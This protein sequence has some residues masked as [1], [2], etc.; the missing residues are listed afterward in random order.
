MGFLK[1][2][3]LVKQQPVYPPDP[4]KS[5]E[6]LSLGLGGFH[7]IAYTEWGDAG[8]KD[9]LVCVHGLTRN[10]RDF[11]PLA[12]ALSATRRVICPDVVGRGASGRLTD[13]A[14]YSYPQY[15]ADMAAVIARIGVAELDWLGTS[16]GGLIGMMMAGRPNT[17]IRR[18]IL[19]DVGPFIPRKALERIGTYVGKDP[20]FPDHAA[21]IAYFRDVMSTWGR[22]EDEDYDRVVEHGVV[23]AEGGFRLRYD[24]SIAAPF[25]GPLAEVDLWSF[26]DAIRCPVLV[27]RGAE[28][29]L[30][31]AD[32]AEKMKT[33]GPGATVVS[34]P[35][36]GHAPALM[37]AEQIGI[38]RDW[39]AST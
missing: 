9:V 3:G 20:L 36:I 22:L 19:N 8:A 38:I 27:I 32:T 14:Q 29:D 12:K 7:K 30:L 5:R 28:S 13:K 2:F 24:P 18:L 33:R 11:D 10:G 17:P 31:P 35:G 25:R 6:L 37:N 1:R 23:P 4:M 16:M 21:A 26:W 39:L 15:C 34:L